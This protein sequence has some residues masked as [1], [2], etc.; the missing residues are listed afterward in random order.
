MAKTPVYFRID[1]EKKLKIEETAVRLNTT[2]SY[3][4]NIIF[5]VGYMLVM[6]KYNPNNIKTGENNNVKDVRDPNEQL[7]RIFGEPRHQFR[8]P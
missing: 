2:A 4:K 3:I 5:Q 1:E 8:R 7:E 6:D